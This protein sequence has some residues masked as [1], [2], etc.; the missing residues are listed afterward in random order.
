[1]DEAVGLDIAMVYQDPT[2]QEGA[3]ELAMQVR[4]LAGKQMTPGTHRGFPPPAGR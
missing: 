1:M 3:M 4:P 2:S